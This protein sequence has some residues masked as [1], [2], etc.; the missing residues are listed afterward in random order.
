MVKTLS[1]LVFLLGLALIAWMGAGFVHTSPLALLVTLVI[2]VFY[3]IGYAELWRYQGDTGA[4]EA[5]LAGAGGEAGSAAIEL[6][7]WLGTLPASLRTAV[8]LR[9]QGE[10]VA[11]PAPL[12]TPYLTGLLVMLGLLGTFVGMMA[13]LQGTVT[14]LEG[15]TELAAIRAGLA[16]PIKGLSMAF[17]TSVAGVGASAALGFISTLSRRQRLA[18]GRLLEHRTATVFKSHS[19]THYREQMLEHAVSQ[20]AQL[21]ALVATIEQG[22]RDSIAAQAA[23]AA[24]LPALVAAIEQGQRDSIAAQAAQ[25]PA[26]VATLEQG[27]RDSIA[28]H[29]EWAASTLEPAIDTTVAG[30][31]TAV[32]DITGELRQAVTG[33]RA[34]AEAAAQRELALLEQQRSLLAELTTTAVAL[35]EEA[36]QHRASADALMENAGRLLADTSARFET[37]VETDSSRLAEVADHFAAS[38]IELSSLGEALGAAMAQFQD[39]STEL[40]A[41][42]AQMDAAL[43]SSAQRSDEQMGYYVAQAREVIDHSVLAQQQLIEQLRQLSHA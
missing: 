8:S 35:R 22:F 36:G 25:L 40:R 41:T 28:A 31:A 12:L 33:I 42:L 38:A 4:L 20:T 37:R 9:I 19:R 15:S 10:P 7:S 21:P 6:G 34:E 5:A 13:T 27:L 16:A 29:G 3:A 1:A 24:Q 30:L 39:N 2:G 32:A 26:L 18:A 11:L 14:A 23:H 17:G 43:S